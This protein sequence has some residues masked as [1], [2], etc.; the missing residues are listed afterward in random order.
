M[1][2]APLPLLDSEGRREGLLASSVAYSP[3]IHLG[4]R[5]LGPRDTLALVLASLATV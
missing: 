1:V 3:S 4:P 2:S 5:L